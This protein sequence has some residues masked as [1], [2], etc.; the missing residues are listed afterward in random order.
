MPSL[1]LRNY[2]NG[3]ETTREVNPVAQWVIDGEGVATRKFDGT[4]CMIR[5]G[6]LYKRYDAKVFTVDKKTGKKNI[7]N[8]TPPED[9]EPCQEVD[10]I[11]GHQPG[12]IP[13]KDIPQDKWFNSVDIS[14]LEDGTYE[15]CGPKVGT[16]AEGFGEHVLI[17]HGTEVLDD[18]PRDY[19]GLKEYLKDKSIEG[20]VWH[21]SNGDMVKIK[22]S[23]FW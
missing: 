17:R 19:D 21:R 3:K 13:V 5:N 12:W 10:E 11:T 20:I 6:K 16:N 18:C 2:D 14:G 1:F 23:D 8:R 7:W 9:F 4:C 22:K 15:L